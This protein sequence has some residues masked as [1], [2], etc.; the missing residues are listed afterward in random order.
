M[1]QT[2]AIWPTFRDGPQTTQMIPMTNAPSKKLGPGC[3]LLLPFRRARQLCLPRDA[4]VQRI[5]PQAFSKD[6]PWKTWIRCNLSHKPRTPPYL[7]PEE[8]KQYSVVTQVLLQGYWSSVKEGTGKRSSGISLKHLQ[9]TWEM[10][11]TREHQE[12]Q[13]TPV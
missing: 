8:S 11:G 10:T 6:Q 2:L 3:P 7:N 5:Q 1:F 12:M 9:A 4:S 13:T